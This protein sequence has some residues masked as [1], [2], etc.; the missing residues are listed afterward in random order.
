MKRY[1]LLALVLALSLVVTPAALAQPA[2]QDGGEATDYVVVYAK[3]VSLDAARQAVQVAG[4][5]IVKENAAVGVATVRSTNPDFLSTVAGQPAL[6]G[7][8]RNR[9]IGQ[10]AK[11]P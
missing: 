3:G 10:A 11:R 7:A 4:G 6:M 9:P 2:Q 5:E 1:L 8:T